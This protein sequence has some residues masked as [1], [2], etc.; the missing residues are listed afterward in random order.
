ML[1]HQNFPGRKKIPT[2]QDKKKNTN[3][4]QGCKIQAIKGGKI[5]YTRRI[6]KNESINNLFQWHY[7]KLKK[8]KRKKKSCKATILPA[9]LKWPL[10]SLRS[11]GWIV[12]KLPEE[13]SRQPVLRWVA[14]KTLCRK[15]CMG[16][17]ALA[18]L[19]REWEPS[20]S[21]FAAIPQQC[22]RT[23]QV[24]PDSRASRGWDGELWEGGETKP[25]SKK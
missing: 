25:R 19:G 1:Q 3:L 20:R 4:F 12:P 16:D 18:T 17:V 7:P 2:T 6:K 21:P 15:K 14:A 8:K 23:G 10:I 9:S 22:T 11:P 13:K 5:L 24:Q